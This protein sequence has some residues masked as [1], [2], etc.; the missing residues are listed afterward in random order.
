MGAAISAMRDA[1]TGG[2]A[3]AQEKAM[4]DLDIL[5]KMVDGQLDKF[6]AQ[7]NV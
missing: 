3:A 1:I 6:E 7:L 4:Q 2:D 5:Q